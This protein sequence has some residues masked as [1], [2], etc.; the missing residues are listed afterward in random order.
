MNAL[1]KDAAKLVLITLVAGIALGMVYGITKDPIAAQEKKA[2]Q[3]AF[4]EVFPEADSFELMEDF[5][6]EKAAEIFA[7]YD[8]PVEDHQADTLNQLVQAKNDAGEVIG[9]IFD[10][11]T[12]KGYGGDI[13]ATVG[14]AADGTVKGYSI[15]S[16]SETAGLGMKAKSDPAWAGQFKDKKVD[17]FQV[18]KD[19]SGSSDDTA[20]DAISGATITSKAMTGAI[21]NCIACF[22]ALEGGDK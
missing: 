12:H 10:I 5:T 11:T 19:G 16:I 21:N 18:V 13:E 15:L 3:A 2:Q 7:G 17:H 20:I 22:Q 1:I 4:K 14:I 8:N 6:G 9:Y